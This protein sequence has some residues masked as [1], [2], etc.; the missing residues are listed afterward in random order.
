MGSDR[1]NAEIISIDS[2]DDDLEATPYLSSATDF[3]MYYVLI[4]G[5][6]A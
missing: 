1:A 4:R 5:E 6:Y 3:S 2:D